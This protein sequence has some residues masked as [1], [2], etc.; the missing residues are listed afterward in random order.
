MFI[1]NQVRLYLLLA[2]L[3]IVTMGCT[4]RKSVSSVF[5][6]TSLSVESTDLDSI[7]RQEKQ[8]PN[9]IG[10]INVKKDFGAKG[11]G[12]TDDTEA[13]LQAIEAPYGDYTRPKIL[14]FPAGTYLVSDTLQLK[15][16]Q[17]ACCVTFQGQGKEQTVIQL[18][19][20]ADGFNSKSQPKSVI[21]TNKGNAAFRNFF[22]DLTVN[23]G[24]NNPGAIGIDYISNNHGGIINVA[25]KSEDGA[26][27][28]GLSMIRQWP[29]PSLIKYLT[30]EGFDYGIHTRHPEYGIVFEH[31]ELN[32]QN[33]AGILNEGN[34]LAIRAVESNNTVPAIDNKNGLIIAI[35]GN[36]QGGDRQTVAIDNQGY[37]YARDIEAKNYQSV[38]KNGRKI[39]AE[40]SV[41]EYVSHPIYSLFDSPKHSLNLA[42]EETP[43]YHD[44][45]LEDWANVKEY[46][47]IQAAMNSGKPIV[48][49]P[50]GQYKLNE[51]IK[52]PATV[53]KIV[54][55]ES[56]ININQ[57]DLQAVISISEDSK[58]PLIIEGL[59]F[60]NT[61][62]DHLTGRTLSFAHS[63]LGEGSKLNSYAKSGK[64]FLEDVQ[65]DLEVGKNQEVWARQL[66]SETLSE[67][68]TKI[69]NSGGK[70]WILGLKTE[71]KGTVIETT[72]G[73]E[74]ELLG[75]LIYPVKE[76]SKV[77][78]EQPA[79]INKDSSQSLIY[80]ISSYG[81]KRNYEIQVEEQRQGKTKKLFSE[82]VDKLKIPLFVGY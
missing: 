49:F 40:A 26:G 55:F 7:S 23:T 80:S 54:G 43:Y 59:L 39:V 6:G 18:Q 47:S 62:I 48:Y 61:T 20:N 13:I 30:V 64:L 2:L 31:I 79:F 58:Q 35:E 63:K 66:N 52:V 3:P 38:I 78:L 69:Y 44:N 65:L 67:A 77:D 42:I 4:I 19:D 1:R 25:I 24:K 10:W 75:T 37:L 56:F 70:L 15:K 53:E 50:M 76:F 21:K 28:T 51:A 73:G 29:G 14:F 74:T 8:F 45:D 22:R 81:V 27:K 60:F 71:G 36:F 72:D 9:D 46:P 12:I 68:K 41:E 34:T 82:E 5:A 11:D 33:I 17:Y 16:G 32:Q 57:K